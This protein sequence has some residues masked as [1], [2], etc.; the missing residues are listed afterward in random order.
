[1]RTS[2]NIRHIF[3]LHFYLPV[4]IGH[5]SLGV[6]LGSPPLNKTVFKHTQWLLFDSILLWILVKHLRRKK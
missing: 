2:F 5:V 1:M 6:S 4:V 3:I